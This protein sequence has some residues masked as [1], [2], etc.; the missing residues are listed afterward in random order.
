MFRIAS[1]RSNERVGTEG[2]HGQGEV[3]LRPL[4]P[5]SPLPLFW[6]PCRLHTIPFFKKKLHGESPRPTP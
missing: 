4:S 5:L 1:K 3:E 6:F 2:S